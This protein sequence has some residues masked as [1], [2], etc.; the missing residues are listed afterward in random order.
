MAE[1]KKEMERAE[2]HRTIWD[3]NIN[4]VYNEMYKYRTI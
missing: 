2:L 4:E 1:N 3:E